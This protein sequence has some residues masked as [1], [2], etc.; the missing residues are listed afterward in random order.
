MNSAPLGAWAGLPWIAA[1]PIAY[2]A[3]EVVH[4]LGIALLLGSLVL[5]ELRVW[6]VAA[7]LP[8]LP[9]A[10]LALPV[11]ATGFGLVAVSGLLMFAAQPASC[12]PIAPSSSS[13]GWCSWPA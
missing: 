9:L 10:R 7:E 4:I 11:T 1:H 2:P 13:S 6:G 3:L 8:V 12:W 5:L